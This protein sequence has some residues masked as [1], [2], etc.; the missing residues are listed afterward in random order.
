M[1]NSTKTIDKTGLIEKNHGIEKEIV[2]EKMNSGVQE[3]RERW[4]GIISD[5][6]AGFVSMFVGIE[7]IVKQPV[8]IDPVEPRYNADTLEL[9]NSSASLLR[10]GVKN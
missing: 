3:I 7:H 8:F 10:V 4:H 5:A 1:E 6:I 9:L 2:I